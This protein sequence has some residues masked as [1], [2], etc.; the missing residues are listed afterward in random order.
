MVEFHDVIYCHT[1]EI[2]CTFAHNVSAGDGLRE[3]SFFFFSFFCVSHVS[4]H[5]ILL[6][7]KFFFLFCYGLFAPFH[8]RDIVWAHVMCWT[9]Y[10]C[11]WV[12]VQVFVSAFPT[13]DLEFHFIFLQVPFFLLSFIAFD[14]YTCESMDCIKHS[15]NC[16]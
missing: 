10:V 8:C 9:L 11:V 1:W 2:T 3:S 5:C 16:V 15:I 13:S 6:V 12:D 4:C 7:L 14:R